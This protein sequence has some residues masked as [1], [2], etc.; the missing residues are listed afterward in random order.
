MGACLCSISSRP[1]HSFIKRAEYSLD[2][3]TASEYSTHG[4]P[5]NPRS[6]APTA[7]DSSTA[8]PENETSLKCN[9]SMSR[10]YLTRG[11]SMGQLAPIEEE[12]KLKRINSR[13]AGGPC[14]VARQGGDSFDSCASSS[15]GSMRNYQKFVLTRS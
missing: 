12:P 2:S 8:S 15:F 3:S 6:V 1:S 5:G 7:E 9:F 10:A 11:P 13:N 4:D 14:S